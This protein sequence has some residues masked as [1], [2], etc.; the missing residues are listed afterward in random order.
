MFLHKFRNPLIATTFL[1]VAGVLAF[2]AHRTTASPAPAAPAPMNP[3]D[4]V[5]EKE[6]WIRDLSVVEDPVRTTYVPFDPGAP[7]KGCWTFGRLMENMAGPNDVSKFILHLFKQFNTNMTVNGWNIP[8]RPGFWDQ[9]IQPWIDQSAANGFDGL[10]LS[11]APFRLNGF[12]NRIDLR[13]GSTYGGGGTSAG[14]GRIVF[15]ICNIDGSPNIGTLI[16]EYE[17][18]AKNCDEIKEWAA[19]WHQLGSLDFGDDYNATL[20]K[21]VERF[22]GKD[23]APNKINGSALNQLRTN[24][25][26]AG[27][28]WQWREFHLEKTT[29]LEQATVAQTPAIDRNHSKLL[30]D[31][32][33]Q[34][35]AA[36]LANNYIVPLTFN[37][38]PFRGGV[39][40]GEPYD[41]FYEAPGILNNDARHIVS[42]NSCVGCHSIE[43]G[44]GFFHST[45]RAAGQMTFL[46]GFLEGTTAF[47]PVSGVP[48]DFNDLKRRMESMCQV[49]KGDCGSIKSAEV[50]VIDA[51]IEV[52]T[53][54]EEK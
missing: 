53:A 43:T 38:V 22:A 8:A 33:N 34:N 49:L 46:S 2:A 44:T 25:V 16:M 52:A 50:A 1:A 10:D 39:S 3:C 31:F 19:A 32:V 28:P 9:I 48:R 11:I 13:Q 7:E 37:G 15:T 21:I 40:D 17:L 12:V 42:L 29:L 27:F 14:E 47:D 24:E 35:E 26:I 41:A 20:Q 23:A 30:R 36:I 6:L 45:P 18:L 51:S 5:I 4:I 54:S